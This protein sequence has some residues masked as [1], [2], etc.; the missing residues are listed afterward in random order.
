M[1]L[2][3]TSCYAFVG[4]QESFKGQFMVSESENIYIPCT[5]GLGLAFDIDIEISRQ[6]SQPGI[7][8]Y[9]LLITGFHIY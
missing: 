5:M 1:P 6:G 8:N 7:A 9:Q 4:F 2:V 3:E